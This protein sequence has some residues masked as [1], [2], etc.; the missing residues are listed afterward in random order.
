MTTS[1]ILKNK[2]AFI[3]TTH[4]SA[5]TLRTQWLTLSIGNRSV[6]C[7]YPFSWDHQ[8]SQKSSFQGKWAEVQKSNPNYIS[9]LKPLLDGAYIMYACIP[10]AKGNHM[11][12]Q[13]IG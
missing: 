8:L 7:I 6:T 3:F 11:T 1:K 2:Q 10:L 12:K 5:G 9:T 4:G 13:N